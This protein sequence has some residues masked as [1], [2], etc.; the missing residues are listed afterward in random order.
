[1]VFAPAEGA[2]LPVLARTPE[3]LTASNLVLTT[4]EALG[5]FLGPAVGGL[6]LAAT[7]TDTVLAVSSFAFLLSALLVSR[8]H[9]DRETEPTFARE[10]WAQRMFAGF[11][12]IWHDANLRVI[13][14]L[15]GTQTLVAGALN[16]LIVVT[17]LELLD[18]GQA[19][20]GFLN[21][22]VGI[23]GLAGG[24][25]AAALVGRRRLASDF[26]IG[27]MLWGIPIALIG[28]YPKP[29]IALI[30][31]GVVGVG[32]I[33]VDVS[34]ITLLQR[35][36]PDEVLSRVMGVVQSVF[37][38][39]LGLGA[40]LAPL[41]IDWFGTR[42][43]LIATGALLP[44]LAAFLWRRL[45]A[46]DDA[47]PERQLE[48]LELVPLFRPLPAPTMEQ[49]ASKLIPL[50]LSAGETVFREGDPGERFY[51]V[52]TGEVLV[53]IDGEPVNRLGRGGYFGEIA[54]LRDVPRTATVAAE[55]DTELQA[56]ER[57]EFIAAV[58]GHAPSADVADAVIA[59]RLGGLRPG[60]ASV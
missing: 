44:V 10:P 50:S 36:V 20:I 48:L 55:Q 13:V 39:T 17:A 34:G 21:S 33:L 30:L 41:L 2:L 29:P 9:V 51:V 27:L 28:L 15:Y 6:L 52:E 4:I 24:F 59:S 23:G 47:G 11:T 31:L 8:I 25:A 22:A 7:S 42:G 18:I 12:T 45:S 43:A 60:M 16:V 3:E 53:S 57:D 19:G 14:V 40:I 38:G 58:T 56:L 46:M 37:V 49:L 5:I 32:T 54:L 35:S 26:G 1:M